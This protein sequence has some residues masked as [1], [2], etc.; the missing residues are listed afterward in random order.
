MTQYYEVQVFWDSNKTKTKEM[1]FAKNLD[2]TQTN[3]LLGKIVNRLD[4]SELKSLIEKH[5]SSKIAYLPGTIKRKGN[6]FL[7][8]ITVSGV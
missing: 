4:W 8:S 5:E 6:T 2:L 7:V 1:V 3:T